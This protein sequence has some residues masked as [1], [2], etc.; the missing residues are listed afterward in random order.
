MNDNYYI[1]RPHHGMCLRFFRGEGYSGAFTTNMAKEKAALEGDNPKVMLTIEADRICAACP[2]KVSGSCEQSHKVVRYDLEVLRLCGL[3]EGDELY[4]SDFEK[5][6]E[7]YILKT[8]HREKI[9]GDCRWNAL[10]KFE[11]E[12]L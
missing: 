1:L 3:R 5:M 6:V 11:G 8:G 12:N 9:C 7:E 2:N 4:F 10:C